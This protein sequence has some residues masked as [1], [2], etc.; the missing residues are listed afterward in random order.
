MRAARSALR[1]PRTVLAL[2]VLLHWLA[3]LVLALSVRHNGWLYYQGGD[4]IWHATTGWLLAHGELP[5]TQ[6][7]Y[8]WPVVLA[9]LMSLAGGD[10]LAV[11]PFLVL[12]NVLVLGPIAIACVY[13]IGAMLA[14][15]RFGLVA[16]AAWVVGPFAAVPLFVERYHDRFVEQFL[17]QSLGLTAMS[18]Y[19]S[20]VCLLVAAF[21]VVR[22][23]QPGTPGSSL[24]DAAA[25]GL[26][27]GVAIGLKPSNAL[28]LAGAGAAYLVVARGRQALQ[29]ALALAPSLIV[30]LVWKERG[31]GDLPVVLP[32]HH[33]AGGE[34]LLAVAGLDRYVDLDWPN[35]RQNMADLR[36][37]FYSVRLL[38]W[39]P[40]AGLLAV[41]RRSAP[42]AG[43]LA[44]WFGTFLL[45][46]GT[47]PLST[48]SSGSFFRFLL[49]AAPAYLLLVAAIPLLVPGLGRRL[50]E[51]AP[52]GVPRPRRGLLAGAAAVGVFVPLVWI[53]L[54]SP[55]DTP[56]RAVIANGILV[57]VDGE[58]RP[59]VAA[60][61]GGATLTWSA[62]KYAE[63]TFYRVLRAPVGS[64]SVCVETGGALDCTLE[65]ESIGTTREPRLV[66]REGG[67]EFT[68]RIGVAANW[69]DDPEGGD[70]FV[71][72][73]P[74]APG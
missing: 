38:Q 31:L 15:R 13:G 28:F 49:P 64:D 14:G 26:A 37:N 7:G 56:D 61:A 39:A 33:L 6:V 3:V 73:P 69:R 70:I 74:V 72:G 25:A 5:P 29:F 53:A 32:A 48:V 60:D 43:L 22:S 50:G 42:V 57:R 12:L 24:H 11:L 67:A 63:P 27:A 41:G 51:A 44:G 52:A 68:Y 45:V 40:F 4:Q 58:L 2:L 1:E 35:F 30:L 47:T 20:M 8:V 66:D 21:F 18:D 71:V 19:P 34:H 17:P 55:Q 54:A 23:L 65:M 16:A 36:E 10:Y 59:E 9:P 46:K 62:E